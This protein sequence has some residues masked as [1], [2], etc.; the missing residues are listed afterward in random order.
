[1]S[2]MRPKRRRKPAVAEIDPE[3]IRLLDQSSTAD[4]PVEAVIRL[5]AESPE[6]VVPSPQRTEALADRVIARVQKRARSQAKYNVFRNLGSFVVSGT[7]GLIR[8]LIAQPEVGG[9]MANRQP[10]SLFIAPIK[11]A[12]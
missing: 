7:P 11:K 3:L 12:P 6:T 10:D 1:M 8:E 4:D 9:A 5:R 2:Q